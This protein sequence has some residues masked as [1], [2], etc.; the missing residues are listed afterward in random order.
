MLRNLVIKTRSTRR[1]DQSFVIP[2]SSLR[3]LVDLARLTASASN[4]QP[5]RYI[6]STNTE[7]NATIFSHLRWAAYLRDWQGPQEGERP[8]AYILILHDLEL[9]HSLD[10]DHGIA[11]QTISLGATEM[12][13]AGC[14][15]G[16]I[17]K[18]G[19]IK[20][21]Q[22]APRYEIMLVIALGKSHEQIQLETVGAE[23]N[24]RYWRDAEGV[25]HVPKRSLD[26]VILTQFA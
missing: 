8:S 7:V 4:M 25:H 12:G 26:D 19:L 23:G 5:L 6:L 2:I 3:E 13:L 14:I 15:V 9:T 22:I 16:S 10:C 21:L 24:I 17:N 1:F 11:A 18:Q 20:D